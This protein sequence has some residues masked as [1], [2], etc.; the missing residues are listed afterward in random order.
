MTVNVLGAEYR[1]KYKT[2][3]KDKRLNDIGGYIDFYSKLIVINKRKDGELNDYKPYFKKELRH[4]IVHAFLYESG[5]AFNTF[6]VD[7]AWALNEE[8]VDWFAIQ[9]DKIHK[10]WQEAGAL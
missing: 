3:K 10:A 6:C 2:P 4:E 9:G 7:G 8:M 5:L 1:I